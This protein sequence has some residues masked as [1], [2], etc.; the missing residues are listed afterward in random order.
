MLEHILIGEERV[1]NLLAFGVLEL[2]LSYAPQFDQASLLIVGISINL[3][4]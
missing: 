4:K 2:Y 3:I 1:F